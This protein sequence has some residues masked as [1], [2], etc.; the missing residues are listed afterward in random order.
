MSTRL[1]G[2]W[3]LVAEQ[4]TVGARDDITIARRLDRP[5]ADI[6]RAIDG[7]L[8]NDYLY[9]TDHGPLALTQRAMADLNR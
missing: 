3:R 5:V 8:R 6:L 2:F 4:I 7:M 9:Q 1:N